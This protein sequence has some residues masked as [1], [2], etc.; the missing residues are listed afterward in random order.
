L[1]SDSPSNIPSR[2]RSIGPTQSQ[3]K[4]AQPCPPAAASSSL[5]FDAANE[6]LENQPPGSYNSKSQLEKDIVNESALRA[7]QAKS[8]GSVLLLR[9]WRSWI[10]PGVAFRHGQVLMS[11][12]NTL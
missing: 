3:P 8:G 7:I 12:F 6:D 5:I 11:R 2:S 9:P 1:S 10:V 4:P